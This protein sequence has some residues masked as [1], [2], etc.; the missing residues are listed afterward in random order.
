MAHAG[1]IGGVVGENLR[2]TL[3]WLP[4]GRMLLT[5]KCDC[6]L[7]MGLDALNCGERD[8]ATLAQYFERLGFRTWLKEVQSGQGAVTRSLSL[9][10]PL[11]QPG[12]RSSRRVS[13]RSLWI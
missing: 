7:P 11:S 3:D 8:D 6:D 12:T 9:H 2:N 4:K 13:R 1:E 10:F 5:V